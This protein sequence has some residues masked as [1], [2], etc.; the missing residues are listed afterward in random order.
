MRRRVCVEYERCIGRGNTDVS[1][2]HK[3][4]VRLI[5]QLKTDGDYIVVYCF[6]PEANS[7][8]VEAALRQGNV[9]FD[10]IVRNSVRP[11]LVVTSNVLHPFFARQ[12]KPDDTAT[13]KCV[14]VNDHD[15]IPSRSFNAVA[16]SRDN[17]VTKSSSRTP[18]LGELFFY[19]HVPADVAH[20]FPAIIGDSPVGDPPT[21]SISSASSSSS[22]DELPVLWSE[23][24][25]GGKC[26]QFSRH[27]QAPSVSIRMVH[28]H[29]PTFSHLL[30]AR[31]L[32]P[33]RLNK[34]LSSLL[35]LH[36]STGPRRTCGCTK[37]SASIY[38]NYARKLRCRLSQYQDVYND[39]ADILTADHLATMQRLLDDYENERRGHPVRVVHGDP[40]LC[41]VISERDGGIKFVDM[42]GMQGDRDFTLA[43]DAVYDL[44]KCWQSLSGYD[45]IVR[46]RSAGQREAEICWR[47]QEAF[48]QHLTPSYPGVKYRDVVL[49]ASSLYASLVPLHESHTHRVEFARRAVTL[50][51][52]V[53]KSCE[54]GEADLPCQSGVDALQ[55]S[56]T[57]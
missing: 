19:C 57:E 25:A 7:E 39:L 49:V 54:R 53:N 46:D 4:T 12:D 33:G 21:G 56:R 13:T 5:Q 44:A 32:T 42:R 24:A 37:T 23:N 51:C 3:E 26:L 48:R 9:P 45:Y 41:N 47:L 8:A 11:D 40:V 36:R 15:F 35:L 43:G 18:I 27:C 52:L 22:D 2:F 55:Y 28:V 6:D 20:L 31:C 34:L 29:G 10:E 30:T 17:V 50:L 14:P 16:V 38:D 1:Q